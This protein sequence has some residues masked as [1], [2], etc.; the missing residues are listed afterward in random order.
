MITDIDE[1][2]ATE[3][4]RHEAIVSLQRAWQRKLPSFEVRTHVPVSEICSEP[5]DKKLKP[6]W[7]KESFDVIALAGS[8][9][10]AIFQI[11]REDRE[12]TEH[13]LK[14]I[15]RIVREHEQRNF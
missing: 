4:A 3:K 8:K 5:K 9:R 1:F 13:L 15:G 6:I 10:V 14:S 7:R 2:P 11:L 12:T